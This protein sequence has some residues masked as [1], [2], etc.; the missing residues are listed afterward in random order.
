MAVIKHGDI[1][2][3]ILLG[4][5]TCLIVLPLHPFLF[6]GAEKKEKEVRLAI[7]LFKELRSHPGQ[8]RG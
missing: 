6:Q 4:F 7:K 8:P 1:I 5:I 2:Q 3:Y